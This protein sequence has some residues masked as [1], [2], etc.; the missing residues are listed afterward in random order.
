MNRRIRQSSGAR[1]RWYREQ[2]RRR[3]MGRSFH[4]AVAYG[5]LENTPE[6]AARY[7]RMAEAANAAEDAYRGAAMRRP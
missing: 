2:R 6:E 4:D 1:R 5:L 3:V 7:H